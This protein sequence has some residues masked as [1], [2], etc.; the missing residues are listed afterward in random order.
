M[1]TT[2][3]LMFIA[4]ALGCAG[5]TSPPTVEGVRQKFE[6]R[7][8]EMGGHDRVKVVSVH[9]LNGFPGEGT[10]KMEFELELECLNPNGTAV[11]PSFC[12]KGYNSATDSGEFYA[13][14]ENFKRQG[15]AIFK[16]SEN[17]WVLSGENLSFEWR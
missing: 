6:E 2:L 4:T 15:I 1:K 7:L 13:I 10:Y 12:Y 11:Q 14:G 17:G 9:K 5:G 8:I 16:M 3:L